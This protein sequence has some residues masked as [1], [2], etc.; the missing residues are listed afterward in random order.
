MISATGLAKSYG[1]QRVLD[2]LDFHIRKGERVALLGLNGAGKTTLF[3]CLLALT[4]FEGCFG[5]TASR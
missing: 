3:R 1:D 2:G 5:S 4:E